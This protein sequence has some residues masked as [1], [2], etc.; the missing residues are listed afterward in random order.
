MSVTDVTTGTQNAGRGQKYG[1][2]TV[3]VL[4]NNGNPVPNADVNGNFSGTF[5]E[6][7]SGS[8]GA[9][10]TVEFLT[11]AKASGQVSVSF[12][13]SAL[14]H[15]SLATTPTPASACARS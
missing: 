10:G 14:N 9:D 11:S 6:L 2:A 13:V 15:T 1:K 4:D 12:C 7:V 8:T 5:T 3:T